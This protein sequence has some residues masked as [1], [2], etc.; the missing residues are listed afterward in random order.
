MKKYYIA[1]DKDGTLKLFLGVRPTRDLE[2]EERWISEDP[3]CILPS[4]LYP[5]LTWENE[6]I[7][8]DIVFSSFLQRFIQFRDWLFGPECDGRLHA[9]RDKFEEFRLDRDV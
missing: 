6:P 2:W 7:E 8:V 9:I 3:Y 5:E 1:R 4:D